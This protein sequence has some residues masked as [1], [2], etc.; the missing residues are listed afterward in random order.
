MT[1]VEALAAIGLPPSLEA[2]LSEFA[3]LFLKWNQR[4]NLS[5]ARNERE[6]EDH[7]VDC[8]HLIP[9]LHALVRARATPAR[10]LDVGAGGGLP[11]AIVAICIPEAHITALEPVHKKH[12]FLRTVARE[13]ALP[14]FDPRA[15]RLDQHARSDYTAVTS[16]A[17]FDLAE[18]L[19]LGV[20]RGEP[21]GFAF[22]FEAVQRNDLPPGTQR[23]PYTHSGKT[24][25]IVALQR[26]I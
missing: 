25:A 7:L 11:A 12:A 8:L 26:P 23:Y 6:L 24:R 15:E 20:A 21:G 18:W 2:P 5:A 19:R 22:G 3:K 1:L 9:H 10:F 13:L 4:I 17:T 14:H 16:R